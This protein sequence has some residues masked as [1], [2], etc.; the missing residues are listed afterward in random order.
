ML[1]LVS[2]TF[3]SFLSQPP[4]CTFQPSCLPHASFLP[5]PHTLLSLFVPP[6]LICGSFH[7]IVISPLWTSA[8]GTSHSKPHTFLRSPFTLRIAQLLPISCPPFS[9]CQT[10]VL[11]C[12]QLPRCSVP[13]SSTSHV[14]SHLKLLPSPA[15]IA[16]PVI[17]SV[18]GL[19][20]SCIIEFRF[21][22]FSFSICSTTLHFPFSCI[23]VR[24]TCVCVRRFCL[25][26]GGIFIV[27]C[28][29]ALSFSLPLPCLSL[30]V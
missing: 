19:A 17:R 12:H 1:L 8:L 21:S 27:T 6:P 11:L 4:A 15:L 7:P 3:S 10:F 14:Q 30:Y 5:P 13:H 2:A 9:L 29:H 18:E 22:F 25:C 24:L 16:A 20:L 28:T 26:L 23:L